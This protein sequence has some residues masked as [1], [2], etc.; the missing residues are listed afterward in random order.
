M[1][2]FTGVKGYQS[3]EIH[4]RMC[5]IYGLACVAQKTVVDRLCTFQ[6]GGNEWWTLRNWNGFT[7]LLI[8]RKMHVI[9][10]VHVGPFGSCQQ[11][12]NIIICTVHAILQDLEYNRCSQWVPCSLSDTRSTACRFYWNFCSSSIPGASISVAHC[13]RW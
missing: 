7:L 4:M 8:Q 12:Q 11:Q 6:M 5:S 13:G 3:D 9:N 2:K 10:V 1:V